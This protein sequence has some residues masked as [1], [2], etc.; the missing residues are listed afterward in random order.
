MVWSRA[1]S[2][3]AFP[4]S[5]GLCSADVVAPLPKSAITRE[6]RNCWSW[7]GL[8]SAAASELE[9][10]LSQQDPQTLIRWTDDGR[11]YAYDGLAADVHPNSWIAHSASRLFRE[12]PR[13][14]LN[15]G[16]RVANVASEAASRAPLLMP[17][18]AYLQAEAGELRAADEALRSLPTEFGPTFVLEFA[19]VTGALVAGRLGNVSRCAGEVD[20]MATTEQCGGIRALIRAA[21]VERMQGDWNTERSSL[22]SAIETLRAARSRFVVWALAEAVTGAWFAGD[23]HA[24]LGYADA[25][26]EAAMQYDAGGF[27]YFARDAVREN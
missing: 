20:G 11:E 19:S 13:A 18:L 6:P 27:V 14:S 7:P 12:S 25:L 17:W 15:E 5:A 21:H 4:S 23:E 26:R 10:H 24:R 1:R 8:H 3:G 2:S 22:D 9:A 16:R